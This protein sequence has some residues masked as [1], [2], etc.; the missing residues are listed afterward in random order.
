MPNWAWAHDLKT[1]LDFHWLPS[2][3]GGGADTA[4]NNPCPCELDPVQ[5]A[6]KGAGI[7]VEVRRDVEKGRCSGVWWPLYLTTSGANFFLSRSAP[8][9]AA[10]QKTPPQAVALRCWLVL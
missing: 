3:P 7:A 1:Q 4:A 10:S 2:L 6:A 9:G 8:S 5:G